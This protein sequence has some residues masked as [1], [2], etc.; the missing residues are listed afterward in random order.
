MALHLPEEFENY[1]MARLGPHFIDFQRSLNGV[2]PVSLR[3]NPEKL[4]VMSGPQVPW[5][6]FGRYLPERPVFTLDPRLHGGAYYVQ[7]AS[8]MFLEQAIQQSVD[9]SKSLNVLDLCAAP[10]GKSTHALSLISSDSLLIANEVIRS[11]ATVLSENVQKWGHDNVIVTNNDP[12]VF[13]RLP[14]FFDLIIVDAPCSGEG[15]FRR[16]PEATKE[17]SPKNLEMCA[18]RQRRV[19]GEVWPSLKPGGVLIYSTCTYNEKEN[20]ENLAWLQTQQELEFISLSL[21]KSWGVDTIEKNNCIGYQLFPHRV[22]G[23]GFFLSALRKTDGSLHTM[24]AKDTLKYPSELQVSEFSSWVVDSASRCFFLH[25]QTVR[26]IP[27]GKKVELQLVLNHLNVLQAGTAILEIM[28]NKFVPDHALA[29]SIHIQKESFNR[30][31]L[32]KDQALEYLRK[33]PLQIDSEKLGFALI[34]FE[35]LGIGWVNMIQGRYNNI[36]PASWRIRMGNDD[37]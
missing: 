37:A 31:G 11:R 4:V 3:Y 29:L 26:M 27:K 6:Q 25:H 2:P 7:E 33:N 14:G 16:E 13:Q 35:G 12:S 20:L 32:D 34:E 18:L 10:G 28:K 8:S 24:K 5:S 21:E 1:M 19:I 9:L 36:Y 17:W 23:E 22:K 30:I 15:L